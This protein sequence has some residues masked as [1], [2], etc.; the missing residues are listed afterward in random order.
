MD[1]TKF[2]VGSIAGVIGLGIVAVGGVIG[3]GVYKTFKLMDKA[4]D[5]FGSTSEKDS[6]EFNIP[7]ISPELLKAAKGR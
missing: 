2:V 6:K 5:S 7:G 4:V 3:Y 1:N